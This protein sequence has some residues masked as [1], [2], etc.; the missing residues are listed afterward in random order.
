MEDLPLS[1]NDN[2][3]DDDDKLLKAKDYQPKS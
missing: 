1:F 2:D 3:D